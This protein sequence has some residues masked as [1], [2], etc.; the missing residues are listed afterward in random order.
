MTVRRTRGRGLTR[1]CCSSLEALNAYHPL[2]VCTSQ[3]SPCTDKRERHKY[4][5]ASVFG[6][7][8]LSFHVGEI[9]GCLSEGPL[10]ALSL[11]LS[12]F[13]LSLS[14]PVQRSTCF[15][16]L[17][18]WSSWA[19]CNLTVWTESWRS[20]GKEKG[21]QRFS[22]PL[23]AF[24]PPSILSTYLSIKRSILLLLSATTKIDLHHF[25]F[26]D[27]AASTFDAS[28]TPDKHVFCFFPR[29]MFLK[30]AAPPL[31]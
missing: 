4:A 11:S 1:I 19:K 31:Q 30:P 21:L 8:G 9:D 16:C 20:G 24:P 10:P 7:L 13:S 12:F 5:S 29:V 26:Y 25:F 28:E 15:Y 23:I 27:A 6:P 3:F 18:L 22:S 14:S 17:R 2:F